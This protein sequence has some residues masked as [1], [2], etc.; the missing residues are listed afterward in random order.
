MNVGMFMT[1]DTAKKALGVYASPAAAALTALPYCCFPPVEG[2]ECSIRRCTAVTVYVTYV[3]LL[4]TCE[5]LVCLVFCWVFL[6][7]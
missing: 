1:F 5:S 3:L 7:M 6:L 2:T 4:V